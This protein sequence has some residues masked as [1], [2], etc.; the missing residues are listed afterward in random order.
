MVPPADSNCDTYCVLP[1]ISKTIQQFKLGLIYFLKRE[2]EFIN[3]LSSRNTPFFL[4][5]KNDLV[6]LHLPTKNNY[7]HLYASNFLLR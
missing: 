3:G 1:A 4:L 6:L 2:N 5:P 7:L